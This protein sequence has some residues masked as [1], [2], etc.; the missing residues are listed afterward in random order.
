MDGLEEIPQEEMDRPPEETPEP[1]EVA[2]DPDA[3]PPEQ[4]EW[5]PNLTYS[6]NKEER[7]M[8][9]YLAGIIDSKEKE[10]RFRELYTKADGLDQVNEAFDRKTQEYEELTEKHNTINDEYGTFK[11][12]LE[13]LSGLKESD[14]LAFQRH[15]AIPDRQ[16]LERASQILELEEKGVEAQREHERQFQERQAG[17][18]TQL[19]AEQESLRSQSI[20]QEMHQLKM[21]QA[22]SAPEIAAFR[23]EYDKRFGQEGAFE[24]AVKDYGSLQYHQTQ[25]YVEPSVAVA[26]VFRRSQALI[27]ANQPQAQPQ[28][29]PTG[30]ETPNGELPAQRLPNLGK[31]RPGAPVKARVKTMADL[32]KLA[33]SVQGESY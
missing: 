14:F 27:P 5:S 2:G 26:E 1:Q 3:P 15:W 33:E 19:Q 6:F 4:E 25:R 8:D 21:N 20:Q 7:Q 13:R 11:K 29:M 18:Q 30:A 28:E 23:T 17:Y 24:A 31:G 22:M 10:D 9:E 32:R 16:I 12:G